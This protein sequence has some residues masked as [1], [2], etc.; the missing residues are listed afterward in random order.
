M[1]SS[2]HLPTIEASLVMNPVTLPPG[3]ARLAIKPE[4]TGS[5]TVAKMMGMVRVS[6]RSAAVVGV[7]DERTSSG[8]SATSSFENRCINSVS[9][10]DQR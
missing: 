1:S 8:C 4:P 6:C 10:A 2:S 3:R 5:T 7:L 9:S